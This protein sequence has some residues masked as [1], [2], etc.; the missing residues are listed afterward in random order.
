MIPLAEA[1]RPAFADAGVWITVGLAAVTTA[2]GVMASVF[3]ASRM[4][5]MLSLMR[6]FPHRPSDYSV[7]SAP[8][9]GVQSMVVYCLP[10]PGALDLSPRTPTERGGI[11]S[12]REALPD[13][14]R[15]G[16][17]SGISLT[18]WAASLPRFGRSLERAG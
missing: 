5:T 10:S 17:A 9:H 12:R 3:A 13:R 16:N 2:S 14:R 6:E 15:P 11:G 18:S 1:A 7:R 8:I 4:L